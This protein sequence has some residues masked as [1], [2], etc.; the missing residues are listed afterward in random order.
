MGAKRKKNERKLSARQRFLKSLAKQDFEWTIHLF[1]EGETECRYI[2]DIA[3]PKCVK[4]VR[5]SKPV[6]SPHV[7]M[8]LARDWAYA[9]RDLRES[10]EGRRHL[11]WVLFDDDEKTAEIAR[12]VK[13]LKNLP[14]GVSAKQYDRKKVPVIFVGYMKPCIELWGALGVRG[15]VSG[16]PRTHRA[17]ESCLAKMMTGYSHKDDRRYFDVKQMSQT[18]K[19]C[20]LAAQWEST[21]GAF[22]KC[23]NASYFAGIHKLVSLIYGCKNKF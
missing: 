11:I 23:I 12:T 3:I 6:S 5:E 9:H 10:E 22:P 2:S 14:T 20:Q 16:L 15:S 4:I 8:Q 18:P 21:Y 19:A 13:E 7:L 17:M 1:T